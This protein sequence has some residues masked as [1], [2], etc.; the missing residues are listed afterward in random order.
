MSLLKYLVHI[1][2]GTKAWHFSMFKL[3]YGSPLVL[4]RK[5][6]RVHQRHG[7]KYGYIFHK[8]YRGRTFL[9][10]KI[11][12]LDRCV[13]NHILRTCM[14]THWKPPTQKVKVVL[15]PLCPLNTASFSFLI[16]GF[17][18][19][20]PFNASW[21]SSSGSAPLPSF[22]AYLQAWLP[23]T[24]LYFFLHIII[25]WLCKWW[26]QLTARTMALIIVITFL[27]HNVHHHSLL[28]L[29]LYNCCCYAN[30]HA[31]T[32][33]R[34]ILI[35]YYL[36]TGPWSELVHDCNNDEA[37]RWRWLLWYRWTESPEMRK[38]GGKW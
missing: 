5:R 16:A 25:L 1:T 18:F 17:P 22:L 14:R 10:K 31:E 38:S 8:W 2:E 19:F 33:G 24:T 32:G 29:F 21:V 15:F 36:V 20:F 7:H 23:F 13:I 4:Y 35:M 30:E 9:E 12:E 6:V 34:A 26:R 27:F 28:L 3:D 11:R 37:N